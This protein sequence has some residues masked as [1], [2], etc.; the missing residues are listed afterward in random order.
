MR[1]FV[2]IAISGDVAAELGALLGRW[3]EADW[4]VK[5]VR[6]EGLHLT[7]KFLGEV[8]EEQYPPLVDTVAQAVEG[9]PPI[10]LTLTE[11]GAFPTVPRARVL[12]AGLENDVA[13]ELLV[14]RLEQGAGALGFPL[15]GRPYRPHVTLGRIRDGQRLGSSAVQAIQQADVAP[16]S[17][18]AGAVQLYQ[19]HAG[20][21]GARY[22]VRATFPLESVA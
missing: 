3:Q 1:L 5:W 14:H 9:T 18:L 8:S 22:D 15:E 17:C 19:S 12:W 6:P 11:V 21:G 2:A 10:T 20:G 16:V 4:P 13:L 7:L